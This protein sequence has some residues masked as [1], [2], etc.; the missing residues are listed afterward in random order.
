VRGLDIHRAKARV[1]GQTGSLDVIVLQVFQFSVGD[2]RVVGRHSSL[3]VD[4]GTV[5]HN[6][7]PAGAVPPGV[8]QL[9]DFQKIVRPAEAL[10]V[11]PP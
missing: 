4:R 3:A 5:A 1:R 6:H 7:A 2:N 10:G 9:Q 11:F 8:R